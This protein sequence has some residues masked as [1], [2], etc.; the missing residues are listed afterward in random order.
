MD[1]EEKQVMEIEMNRSRKRGWF[2]RRGGKGG[3]SRRGGGRGGD[4]REI[5]G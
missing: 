1:D 5:C 3:V 2:R 4:D